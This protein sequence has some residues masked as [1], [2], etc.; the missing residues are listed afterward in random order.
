M[1][2]QDAHAQPSP[3]QQDRWLPGGP[4]LVPAAANIP[5]QRQASKLPKTYEA[6]CARF[7]A[8]PARERKFRAIDILSLLNL[9]LHSPWARNGLMAPL[10][11]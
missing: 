4:S 5:R 9:K 11:R 7:A 3:C 8:P 1:E 6:I 2:Q 10:T